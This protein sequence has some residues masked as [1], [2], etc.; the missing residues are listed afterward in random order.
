MYDIIQYYTVLLRS[1]FKKINM[2]T[3][4]DESEIRDL[5]VAYAI[6]TDNT[7]AVFLNYMPMEMAEDATAIPKTRALGAIMLLPIAIGILLFN[8]TWTPSTAPVALVI[9]AIN[10]WAI[11]EARKQYATLIKD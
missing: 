5:T 4:K 9:L 3:V 2:I 7:D 10:I 1:S 8:L 6:T 11:V